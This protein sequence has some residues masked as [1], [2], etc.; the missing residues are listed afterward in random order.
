[1]LRKAELH[2]HLFP[3]G[4]PAMDAPAVVEDAVDQRVV[5]RRDRPGEFAPHQIMRQVGGQPQV[6]EAIQQPQGKEQVGGHAVA[7]GLD[8]HRDAGLTASRRQPSR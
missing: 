8:M 3:A 2:L 7:V 4:D 5:L 6:G 1:M